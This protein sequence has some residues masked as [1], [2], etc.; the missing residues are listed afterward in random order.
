MNK[1]SASASLPK[2]SIKIVGNSLV[3]ARM[4]YWIAT[5]VKK[6]VA[7]CSPNALAMTFDY[8]WLQDGE[9]VSLHL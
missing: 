9:F 4:P 1:N 5:G 3:A 7:F 6:I 2:Q 8:A